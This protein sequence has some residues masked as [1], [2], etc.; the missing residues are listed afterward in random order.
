MSNMVMACN[1]FHFKN[2]IDAWCKQNCNPNTCA[3]LQVTPTN[4]C[5]NKILPKDNE[6]ISYLRNDEINLTIT[7]ENSQNSSKHGH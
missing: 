5:L 7:Q 2:H 4:R 1:R 3:E 6:F